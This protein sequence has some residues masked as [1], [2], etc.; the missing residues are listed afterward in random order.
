MK[1]M[2]Q[3]AK[4]GEI[5]RMEYHNFL[6][7][8]RGYKDF[9]EYQRE[10]RHDSGRQQSMSEN[11]ECASY[12]GIYVAKRALLKIYKHVVCMPYGNKG[13]G[14]ICGRGYRI[15]SKSVCLSKYKNYGSVDNIYD[16]FHFDIKK[17]KIA[18]YFLLI[19]FDNRHDLNPLH[20]W[21]IKCDE[22][23]NRGK[24]N[25]KKALI[26]YNTPKSLKKYEKYEVK[27]KLEKLV[28]CCNTVKE[29]SK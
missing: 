8:K 16:V 27:D 21:L 11:K 28:A 1:S 19:A 25:D 3:R 10:W 12:L 5:T 14:F 15:D 2:W 29:I 26:I 23:I 9:N 4:E 20:I 18:D 6:F 22:I 17:N 24:L 13:F 7:Q